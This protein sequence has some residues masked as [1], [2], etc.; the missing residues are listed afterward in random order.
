MQ[1]PHPYHSLS[2]VSH[3]PRSPVLNPTFYYYRSSLTANF[4]SAL[5][6]YS[7]NMPQT[8]PPRLLPKPPPIPVEEP[9]LPPRPVSFFILVKEWNFQASF[10]CD[11]NLGYH[12]FRATIL[13]QLL[14]QNQRLLDPMPANAKITDVWILSPDG[15]PASLLNKENYLA[16]VT[17]Y[18]RE[19]DIGMPGRLGVELCW[20]A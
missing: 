15:K 10:E 4:Q 17:A 8:N 16:W 9:P 7:E 2:H 12:K 19:V 1:L 20:T 14:L 3:C 5:P 11:L 13:D 18:H 6:G